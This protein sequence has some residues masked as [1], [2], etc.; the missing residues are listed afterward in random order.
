MF[1]TFYLYTQ[2]CDQKTNKVTT[3]KLCKHYWLFML[4]INTPLLKAYFESYLWCNTNTFIHVSEI[5]IT[6][7]FLKGLKI[8]RKT[9]TFYTR[10]LKIR[11][12]F[13]RKIISTGLYSIGGFLKKHN[14][15]KIIGCKKY[16]YY[17][18][19]KYCGGFSNRFSCIFTI[20][21]GYISTPPT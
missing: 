21:W 9:Q 11:N 1:Y 19:T 4:I 3:Y 20:F 7:S 6:L 13:L 5:T 2:C 16:Y 18:V 10:Y 17:S 14:K 8:I 12:N 15:K